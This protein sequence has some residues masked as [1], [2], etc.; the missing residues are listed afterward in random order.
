MN[1]EEVRV[2]FRRAPEGRV[3][4]S[5]TF[6]GTANPIE[7]EFLPPDDLTADSV[8]RDWIQ[9]FE[10]GASVSR[11]ELAQRRDRLGHRL[12]ETLFE[13]VAGDL[14]ERL[15]ALDQRQAGDDLSGL[16]L[17]LVLGDALG[18]DD[19]DAGALLPVASLPWEL[20]ADPERGR[21][22]ARSRFVSVVRTVGTKD[23]PRSVKLRVDGQLRV[24]VVDAEPEGVTEINWPA[25][26]ARI[27]EA[28]A[29]W[30]YVHLEFLDHASFAETCRRLEDGFFNVI[31]FIG[32]GGFDKASG[33]WYLLFEK[34][35]Q[36]DRVLAMDIA[37]RFGD[38]KTLRLAVL[39][40]CRTGQLPGEADGDP[41]SG[42]AAALSVAGVPAVVAMQIPV[43]DGMAIEFSEAF[44][45][46][47][48]SGLPIEAAVSRGRS[49]VRLSS[50][51][52]AT[53][54]LYLR[55]S[56]SELFEFQPAAIE[57]T[58]AP[59]DR[60]EEAEEQAPELKIGIR[61]FVASKDFR[62]AEWAVRLSETTERFAPLEEFFE[63]RFI[64]NRDDWNNV[65]LPR[66]EDFLSDAVHQHRPLVLCLA[67]HTS[68][69]FAAGYFFHTKEDAP[70]SLLQFTAGKPFRWS[71]ETGKVPEGPIWQD[72]Q[73]QTLDSDVQDVAV[74]VEIAQGTSQNA[75]KYLTESGTKVGRLVTATIAG[76]AGK[77]RVETGAHAYRL[78]WELQQWLKDHTGNRARRRLHLFIAAPNGF[79]FFCGQL[80]RSLG[81]LRLYEFDLEGTRHGTYEPSL[82]LPPAVPESADGEI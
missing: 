43:T 59:L 27:K 16:R 17:R 67:A 66:L 26:K 24:L 51:E 82:D 73:D 70:L 31:H 80:A 64:R 45:F 74:A 19:P 46:T 42:V 29:K 7:H 38:V 39:N 37:D 79:T 47:L 50:P 62:L 6:E 63:G 36:K 14:R 60:S 23:P 5:I 53:P 10:A 56:S 1:Y 75:A 68:V 34:N 8:Y 71:A 30:K 81:P 2:Q 78:A 18:T 32:H 49:E 54:V 9:A 28:L 76:G 40:A 55:G 77:T 65:L 13:K 52:W 57:S 4:A 48:K 15:T 3:G 61:S 72:F 33:Q 21:R 25:E 20:L 35:R 69:A 44:Y 41:L 22:L 12:F 11:E 58:E